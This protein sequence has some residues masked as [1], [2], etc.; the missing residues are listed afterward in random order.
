MPLVALLPAI[1]GAGGAIGG[2][3]LSKNKQQQQ[4]QQSGTSTTTPTTAP[5]FQPLRD[6]LI[7]AAMDRFS[8]NGLPAGTL[9]NGL[10]TINSGADSARTNIDNVLTA[11]G[12]STSPIAAS[13][14]TNQEL[15]RQGQLNKFQNVDIPQ[16]TDV[17]NLQNLDVARGVLGFGQ[18]TD[19]SST[20]NS[21][22][23]GVNSVNPVGAGLSS[24]SELL[25]YLYGK[26]AFGGGG[27]PNVMYSGPNNTWFN[28]GTR[29]GTFIPGG[30]L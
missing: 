17:R 13:V 18:G 15:S 29:T 26:G 9:E 25:A 23:T 1:I 27:N 14:L 5:E 8:S 6:A 20:G 7:K 12:L 28:P 11:R 24:G 30:T 19:S 2:A 10:S 22:G 3:L 4:Q 16:M 21:S